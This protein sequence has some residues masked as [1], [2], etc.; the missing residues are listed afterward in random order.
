VLL[1]HLSTEFRVRIGINAAIFVELIY[2]EEKRVAPAFQ[3][4]DI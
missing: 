2:L 4:I 3:S 1:G